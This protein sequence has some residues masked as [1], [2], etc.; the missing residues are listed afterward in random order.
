[1]DGSRV[2]NSVRTIRVLIAGPDGPPKGAPEKALRASLLSLVTAPMFHVSALVDSFQTM[3]DHLHQHHVDLILLDAALEQLNGPSGLRDL[4]MIAPNA[5]VI[6][7]AQG[8]VRTGL[9]D[10]LDAG[11]RGCLARTATLTQMQIAV[12]AVLAGGVYAPVS[13]REQLK[14]LQPER[15]DGPPVGPFQA[16]T[17]RQRQI[18]ALVLEGQDTK[19]I[20]RQLDIGT[21]SVRIHL[22]AIYRSAMVTSRGRGS[23]LGPSGLD[24][25]P[26]MTALS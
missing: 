19:A 13:L 8:D 10:W 21:A 12:K 24:R 6:V 26:A 17:E 18:I 16:L 25:A 3:L 23:S 20:A 1:M 9:S 22:L 2:I 4:A 14:R 5:K 11:A 15:S 7:I